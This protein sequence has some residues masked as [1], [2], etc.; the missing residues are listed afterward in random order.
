MR[1]PAAD[2][3]VWLLSLKRDTLC[4]H[5]VEY[6]ALEILFY[7]AMPAKSKPVAKK[8]A[9]KKAAAGGAKAVPPS[10]APKINSAVTAKLSATQIDNAVD[11]ER[12]AVIH[13]CTFQE[14][15]HSKFWQLE[16]RGCTTCVTF[17]RIGSEGGAPSVKTHP[18]E[19]A[20]EKFVAKMIGEKTKKVIHPRLPHLS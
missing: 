12:K 8:T 18:S 11:T 2:S 3:M 1:R 4:V 6:W 7:F 16:Q 10:R 9:V 15:T 13:R 20:T 14:G 19:E 5:A 17:G